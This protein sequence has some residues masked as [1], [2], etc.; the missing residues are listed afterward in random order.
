MNPD[1][2]RQPTDRHVRDVVAL[3]Y[4]RQ[5]LALGD[6]RQGFRLL[7][8][9]ELGATTEPDTPCLRTNPTFLGPTEDQV[10][11]DFS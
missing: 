4:L 8:L 5:R 9:G 10:T 7:M 3:R 2:H 6:P 11:F 1:L